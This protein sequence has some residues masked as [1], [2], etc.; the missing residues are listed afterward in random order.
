MK[1]PNHSATLLKLLKTDQK[2]WKEFAHAKYAE[3]A[4][5]AEIDQL[6]QAL[7]KRVGS[8]ARKA[9]E[10][11]DVIGEPSVSN[12]G[13]EAAQALSIL[14]TH[15]SL[16][17]TKRVLEAFEALYKNAPEDTFKESIPAMTDWIAVLEHKPQRFGT[18]WLVDEKQYPFLPTVEDF[19]HVNE[20]REAYGIGPLR[21]LKSLVIPIKDQP[22]LLRPVSE[23]VMR[24]PTSAELAELED[25]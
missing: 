9:L 17:T 25:F 2:E 12:I 13:G 10:I 24:E 11:L 18:I 8:R 6:R 22:W 16:L 20:R 23:A 3:K 5:P 14:A 4:S 15:H 7:Q 1:Y 19:E 21:W